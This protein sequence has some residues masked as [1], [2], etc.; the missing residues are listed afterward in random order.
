MINP[1]MQRGTPSTTQINCRTSPP[2]AITRGVTNH[3]LRKT[4]L[5]PLFAQPTPSSLEGLQLL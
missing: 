3:P 2:A 1:M 5:I 4:V